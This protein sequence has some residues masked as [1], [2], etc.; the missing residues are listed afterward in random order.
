[1][2]I[3]IDSNVIVFLVQDYEI[4][5]RELAVCGDEI[6]ETIMSY[7][8][9]CNEYT[10]YTTSTKEGDSISM[11]H[12]LNNWLLIWKTCRK[13]NYVNLAMTNMEILYS[14]LSTIDLEAMMINIMMRQKDKGGMIAINSVVR[15]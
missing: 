5:C 12:I 4:F 13:T 14:E 6:T 9:L 3:C 8:F 2:N 7:M 11:E 15:Y 10:I 1:M